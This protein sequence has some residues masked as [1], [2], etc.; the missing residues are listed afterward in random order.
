MRLARPQNRCGSYREEKNCTSLPRFEQPIVKLVVHSPARNTEGEVKG[1]KK[2][3]KENRLLQLRKASQRTG[4]KHANG[5][6]V[7]WLNYL[8][9]SNGATFQT[10]VIFKILKR[11]TKHDK[12][13]KY[14]CANVSQYKHTCL[15]FCVLG[16]L[17][18]RIIQNGH[19]NCTEE[20]NAVKSC[21]TN[22]TNMEN[23]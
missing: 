10:M 17:C 19:L 11:F 23:A 6:S 3:K 7:D 5:E 14:T 1:E 15:W 8:T 16:N 18:T 9:R 13:A 4:G 2:G 21:W 12:S 20:A 22:S